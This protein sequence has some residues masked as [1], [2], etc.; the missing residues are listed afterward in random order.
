M[1]QRE[2]DDVCVC[3]WCVVRVCVY[4]CEPIIMTQLYLDID[5]AIDTDIVIDIHIVKNDLHVHQHWCVYVCV[6]VCVCIRV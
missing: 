2:I 1:L 6:G 5:I 3:V 4:V